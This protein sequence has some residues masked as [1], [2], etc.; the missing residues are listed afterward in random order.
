MVCA[1]PSNVRASV[2]LITFCF[3]GRGSGSHE[4]ATP[5]AEWFV[6]RVYERVAR[7]VVVFGERLRA[8]VALQALLL[9]RPAW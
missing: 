7:E 2:L 3:K 8:L 6:A 4:Y 1:R 5:A 9:F